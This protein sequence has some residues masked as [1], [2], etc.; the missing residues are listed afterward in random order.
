[1]SKVV[2]TKH[3]LC[4]CTERKR[5]PCP[6]L[7]PRLHEPRCHV[8]LWRRTIYWASCRHF[9]FRD[10][11]IVHCQCVQPISVGARAT[12]LSHMTNVIGSK[13]ANSSWRHI[14][15]TQKRYNIVLNCVP[16][17]TLH[18]FNYK[19]KINSLVTTG[20]SKGTPGTPPGSKFFHF[21]AVFGKKNC[22]IID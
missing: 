7:L 11:V 4:T 18:C 8:M 3:I 10:H 20:G 13:Y 6:F 19:E 22:Q 16:M 21:H 9:V 14:I 2:K 1:M 5:V 12:W 15:L 17:A